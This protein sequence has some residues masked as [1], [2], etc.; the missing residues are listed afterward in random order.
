MP[1]GAPGSDRS[2]SSG[3]GGVTNGIN[4]GQG[5]KRRSYDGMYRT[6]EP[7]PGPSSVDFGKKLWD[8]EEEENGRGP[9]VSSSPPESE[10][11]SSDFSST[12]SDRKG[13][14]GVSTDI[15]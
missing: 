9:D 4:K 1:S 8:L 12:L 5:K 3:G 15:Y 11:T 2:S 7:L 13:G 14:G 10:I 6:H